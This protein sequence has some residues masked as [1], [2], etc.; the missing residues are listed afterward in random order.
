M[1]ELLKSISWPSVASIV[2][3][4]TISATISYILQRNSFAE[5]RRQKEADRIEGR[6]ALGLALFQKMIRIASTLRCLSTVWI[7]RSLVL[8][9]RES[10]V[11]R[12]I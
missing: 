12:G 9:R 11:S 4:A 8:T 10:M 5:A 6:K 2:F 7:T 1:V 3:G